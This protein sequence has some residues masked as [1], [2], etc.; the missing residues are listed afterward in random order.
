[1]PKDAC[2]EISGARFS[3][4]ANHLA[5]TLFP[6]ELPLLLKE[7]KGT[8]ADPALEICLSHLV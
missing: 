4:N 8:R 7:L 1:M 6:T 5:T 3:S 2:G